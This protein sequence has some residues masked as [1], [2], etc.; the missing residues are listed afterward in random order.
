MH[1]DIGDRYSLFKRVSFITLG[2]DAID[3]GTIWKDTL[4]IATVDS[5]EV[6][7]DLLCSG[8][9]DGTI[10]VWNERGDCVKILK[11]HSEWCSVSQFGRMYCAVA[12][13]T[14]QSDYGIQSG[15]V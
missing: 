2:A 4:W 14:T 11:G 7:N 3:C 8:S 12:L 1:Q 9:R 5:F 10:R 15:T 6:W 13:E